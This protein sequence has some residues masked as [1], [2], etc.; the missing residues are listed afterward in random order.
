M[1][2][3]APWRSSVKRLFWALLAILLFASP[4]AAQD[5]LTIEQSQVAGMSGLRAHWDKPIMLSETGRREV[6]DAV[7]KDRGQTA[8]WGTDQSGPIAFDAQH[9]YLLVRFPD[10]ARKIA[11]A[12]SSGKSVA[13]VEL[14]LPYRDE[15]LWPQSTRGA[16]FPTADGYRF[17]MNWDVDKLYRS[18][19]PNWHAVAHV[20]RKPWTADVNIGP[21][22]N[23][24]ING[25]VYWKRFGASDPQEDRFPQQLGPVEVSSYKPDGRMDVT[26]VLTDA[27]FG[28]S[29]SE[30]LSVLADCGFVVNKWET[31]D[32]RFTPPV[33]YE[34]AVSTGPRAILIQQP[35][36]VVTFKAG[37][38][39]SVNVNPPAPVDVN[40]LAAKLTAKPQGQPTAVVPTYEQIVALNEKFLSRPAWMPDWQYE[41]VMQ[42]LKLES[43]GKLPMFFQLLV[44]GHVA[45]DVI[46]RVKG[47]EPRRAEIPQAELDYAV[48]LAW[49]DW[50]NGRP[51]RYWEGHL[52]A[53]DTVALWYNCRDAVPAAVQDVILR[54]WNAYLMPDRETELDPKLRRR[55]DQFDGKLVH[56]MV[57]DP[58][59][60]VD[61]DGKQAQ[62]NQ[63]DTYY[64]NTG[65]WRGNKSYY[66]SGFTREMSTANFNS[67]ATGGALLCGQ[68]IGSERAIADGRA[69]LMQFPFWMWTHSAGVGQEF[70]DHYYWAIATTSNKSFVDFCQQ[71]QDQMAGWSII[72]KTVNDL[73]L[74]YHPNLKKLLGPASRTCFKY[75]LGH[76]DGL[77]HTLHVLSPRGA[78]CD[79]ETGVLPDLTMEK[80]AKGNKNKPLSAWG[81]DVPPVT[82]AFQT[83]SGPWAAPWFTEMIDDKPLPWSSLVEK[84]GDP[85]FT[86]FGV[87]YGLS[88]I[89]AKP[90]RLHMNAHWRRRPETPKS[91]SEIG[92]LDM[93]IGFN[94]TQIGNDGAGV[95]SQQG[96]YKCYQSGNKLLMLARPKMSII[97][98]QAGAR[99]FGL[100][101]LPAQPITSVQCTAAFFN[102]EKPAPTWEIFIDGQKV[103]SLPAY[104]KNSQ[105][106]TVRDGVTYLAI[107]PLPTDD[108]GRDEEVVLEAGTPQPEAYADQVNIQP[109]LL[110]HS[111][112]FKGEQAIDAAAKKKLESAQSG[113]LVEMGDVND[114]GSFENFQKRVQAANLKAGKE[115][116]TYHAGDQTLVAS[117]DAFTVN[118]TDPAA[119]LKTSNLWQD[120]SLSQMGRA[121]LEKNGA[122]IERAKS[123]ANMNLQTFPRQ[124][125][126]VALNLLPNYQNFRFTEPGG[127]RLESDG[128][129]SMG[130]FAIKDSRQIDIK[131]HPFGD[132][133]LPKPGSLPPATVLFVSGAKSKPQ[134]MLNDKDVTNS[135]KTWKHDG[136]DGWLVPLT[137]TRPDDAQI[138]ARLTAAH[139]A[140]TAPAP[141]P[142]A[143]K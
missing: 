52:T 72:S 100:R 105:V 58:R 33:V 49:I 40:A 126:Y 45:V 107:R 14:V 142:A 128:G 95:I 112:F 86:Y 35:K 26:A 6:K 103:Q 25:A 43:G 136:R 32:A 92:T 143:A 29:L 115:S 46:A 124:K 96:D 48:Y 99:D 121:R 73:A 109:A 34:W 39:E 23:A 18:N 64:K 108:A 17:R 50:L 42:L 60:G 13:K 2:R 94:Q 16:D 27:A 101:K 141:E 5:V 140:L 122:I 118:G 20:L 37:A 117:W 57:D 87:N 81:H 135:L 76:Q 97:A 133:Y 44:P 106:I 28:K 63:G 24:A 111:Y 3:S 78:L 74:A 71:P 55:Y 67:S 15:E 62:W 82:V 134:V 1:S 68:I 98:Q 93:R 56:P 110:V 70:I 4:V 129:L 30:R 138:A 89:R 120:T 8:V 59:V 11:Q 79:M 90:Q 54:N 116:L 31:Y 131:Y 84:E 132:E 139:Q 102:Y 47:Q 130:Q 69:G 83:L 36:L 137:T 119:V 38:G 19:R 7:V 53:A 77:Y 85:V 61:K 51:L 75:V 22:Y 88:S 125:I 113:F 41:R 9:R 127:V 123:W 66:R 80:D 12:L 104:A 10:A 114:S 91:M 65:D 21:T